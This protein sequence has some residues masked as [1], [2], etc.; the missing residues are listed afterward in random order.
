MN[1]Q[2]TNTPSPEMGE[3]INRAWPW[4]F[5][6]ARTRDSAADPWQRLRHAIVCQAVIDLVRP[7][8]NPRPTLWDL[9]TARLFVEQHRTLLRE[10]G[11]P[12]SKIDYLLAW[13]DANGTGAEAAHVS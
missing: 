1:E 4:E 10:M 3:G 2:T 12:V 9:R 5:S 13:L 8:R 11:I 7:P 6:N